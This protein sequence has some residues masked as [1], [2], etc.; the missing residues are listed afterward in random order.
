[1]KPRHLFLGLSKAGGS[2]TLTRPD[3]KRTLG[4]LFESPFLKEIKAY[5]P[6]DASQNTGALWR[7]LEQQSAEAPE[8]PAC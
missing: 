3:L 2:Q 1:M 6:L 7:A 8:T 5:F 4:R